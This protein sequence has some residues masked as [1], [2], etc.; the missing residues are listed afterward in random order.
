MKKIN[1][2]EF[3][4]QAMKAKLRF[5]LFESGDAMLAVFQFVVLAFEGVTHF[6]SMLTKLQ[7]FTRHSYLTL[8]SLMS[9]WIPGG[10]AGKFAFAIFSNQ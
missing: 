5:F 9:T 10:V 2:G 3:E 1:R 8:L 6:E 7:E 4:S